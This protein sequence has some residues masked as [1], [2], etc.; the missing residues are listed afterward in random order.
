MCSRQDGIDNICYTL[1]PNYTKSQCLGSWT[2][3]GLHGA[4][5][6]YLCPSRIPSVQHE[7]MSNGPHMALYI[8]KACCCMQ[9]RCEVSEE[10]TSSP[11]F[12]ATCLLQ[13]A[14]E[15]A[16]ERDGER[17]REREREKRERE[18]YIYIYTYICCKVKNWSKIWAFIS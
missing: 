2:L 6:H 13:R 3:L 10:P 18:R 5:V 9:S 12:A 15:P 17:E 7:S 1:C 14:S 11:L 8:C 4:L 16:R